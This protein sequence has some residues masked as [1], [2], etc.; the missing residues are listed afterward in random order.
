MLAAMWLTSFFIQPTSARSAGYETISMLAG[1]SGNIST[2]QCYDPNPFSAHPSWPGK[3]NPWAPCR[4]IDDSPADGVTGAHSGLTAPTDIA[5]SGTVYVQNDYLPDA[6]RGGYLYAVD[7][8]TGCYSSGTA[9]KRTKVWIYYYD[10][11][12]P[13]QYTDVHAVYYGHMVQDTQIL[14]TWKRWNNYYATSP[15]WESY[16]KD[17]YLNN[18]TSGGMPIGSVKV[19]PTG[20][21]TGTHLHQET[22]SSHGET[23]DTSKYSE[24]C[25]YVSGGQTQS[26]CQEPGY[27]WVTGQAVTGRYSDIQ[28][29]QIYVH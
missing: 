8:S 7:A 25:W 4:T 17:Y 2:L 19:N 21:A 23:W 13:N 12:S 29:L 22:D 6:V 3:P 15:L 14:N 10:M 20:C 9:G 27:S 5:G 28:F 18:L 16:V 24:G 11:S 1:V 26:P